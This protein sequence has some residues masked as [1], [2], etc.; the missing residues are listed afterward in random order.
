M[1]H[2][3]NWQLTRIDQVE[4]GPYITRRWVYMHTSKRFCEASYKNFQYKHKE[5]SE[6]YI[7]PLLL[8]KGKVL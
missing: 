6:I 1:Y 3:A 4:Q 7:F 8:E 5:N 2:C